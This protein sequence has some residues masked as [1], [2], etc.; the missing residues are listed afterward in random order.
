MVICHHCQKL[1]QTGEKI[2]RTENCPYCGW[3]LHVCLNCQHYDPKAYNDCREPQAERVLDK[4]KSNF[5]D[6]FAAQSEARAGKPSQADDAKAK[7]EAM[8][9]KR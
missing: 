3:D 8:F 9:K 5:C 4:E 2:G 7:L 1:A 6:L